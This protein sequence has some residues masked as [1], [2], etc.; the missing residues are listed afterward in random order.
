M[1]LVAEKC[2]RVGIWHSIYS[3]G[4]ANK[5]SWKTYKNK[6]LSYLQYCQKFIWLAMLQKLPVNNF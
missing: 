6:N 3:Y 5:K 2:I 4:K 1:L